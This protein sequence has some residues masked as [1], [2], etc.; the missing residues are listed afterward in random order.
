MYELNVALG[1][2]SKRHTGKDKRYKKM[3]LVP[4]VQPAMQRFLGQLSDNSAAA[5]HYITKVAVSKHQRLLLV[6][7]ALLHRMM[8]PNKVYML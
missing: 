4:K 5:R 1:Y 3:Q 2:D 8:Q 6:P 7:D